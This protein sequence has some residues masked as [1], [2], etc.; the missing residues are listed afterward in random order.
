MCVVRVGWSV[1][2]V[3]WSVHGVRPLLPR[4]FKREVKY[5]LYNHT[6]LPL[7]WTNGG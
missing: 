6:F 2:R 1:V 4:V 7:E 5:S 3:G